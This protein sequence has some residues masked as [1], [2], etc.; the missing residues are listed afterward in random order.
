MDG[1]TEPTTEHSGVRLAH[2]E[3]SPTRQV[4][5]RLLF[6]LFVFVLTVLLVYADRDGYRDLEDIGQ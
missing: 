5:R 3:A 2:V 1:D 6:A 4:S